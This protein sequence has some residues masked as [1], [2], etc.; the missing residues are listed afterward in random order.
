MHFYLLTH[1]AYAY[2]ITRNMVMYV[3]DFARLTSC[4]M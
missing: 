2:I 1:L 4:S 3:N